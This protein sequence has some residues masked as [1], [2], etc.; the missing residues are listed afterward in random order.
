MDPACFDWLD[1][2][3]QQQIAK[4]SFYR[5]GLYDRYLVLDSDSYFIRPFSEQDLFGDPEEIRL[6]ASFD[7]YAFLKGSDDVRRRAMG[8]LEKSLY[9]T[10]SARFDDAPLNVPRC[11]LKDLNYKNCPADLAAAVIP[12]AFSKHGSVPK[13]NFMP[14]P[15]LFSSEIMAAFERYITAEDLTF[16]DLIHLSPWEA[17]WYGHFALK[18]HADRIRTVEPLFF[19]F[20]KDEHLAAARAMG[21]SR[22]TLATNFFGLNLAARHQSEW[23]L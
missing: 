9:S 2:W 10:I 1:G 17:D 11:F 20:T 12:F 13:I 19:H 14:P 6:V 4:L 8:V 7:D 21:M 16:T 15:M 22:Q 5:T 3:R 23:M 18:F